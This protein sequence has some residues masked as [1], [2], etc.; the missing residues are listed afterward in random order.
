MAKVQV[1]FV[2]FRDEKGNFLP[3]TKPIYREIPDEVLKSEDGGFYLYLWRADSQRGGG[4]ADPT[5]CQEVFGAQAGDAGCRAE[6]GVNSY[7]RFGIDARLGVL[8]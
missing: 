5:F 4:R 6:T 3:K 1:G 8:Q 2:A 7:D